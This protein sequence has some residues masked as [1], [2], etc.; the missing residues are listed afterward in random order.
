[1]LS[2]GQHAIQL[3]VEDSTGK[4]GQDSIVI[5]V[6]PP[7]SAPLCEIFS[8]EDGSAGQEGSLVTF[9]GT[10]SDVDVA[11]DVLTVTW[12]SDKDGEIGSLNPDSD[13]NIVF[14]YSG[15]SVD[16]HT[17]SM[18]VEDEVGATCTSTMT[19]TVGTCSE[20][21]DR[22]TIGWRCDQ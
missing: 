16:T 4:P 19:Y 9:E 6:G 15:L 18:Q 10:A 1:M 21:Y 13:G 20:H 3:H 12:S 22:C 2:E 17:I 11:S 7:N 14:S 8:P 5:E